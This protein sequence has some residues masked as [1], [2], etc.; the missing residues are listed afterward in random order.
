MGIVLLAPEL[1]PREAAAATIP[2][3]MIGEVDNPPRELVQ[4]HTDNFQAGG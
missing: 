1:L 3:V 4:I 2:C